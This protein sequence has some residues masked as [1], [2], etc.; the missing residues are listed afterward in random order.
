V[1]EVQNVAGALDWRLDESELATIDE[2]LTY[3]GL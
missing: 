2:K 3:M 1:E